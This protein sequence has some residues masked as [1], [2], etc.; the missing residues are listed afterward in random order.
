M[1][2]LESAAMIDAAQSTPTIVETAISAERPL[3][4]PENPPVKE[5]SSAFQEMAHE[6]GSLYSTLVKTC[7]SKRLSTTEVSQLIDT[8]PHISPRLKHIYINGWANLTQELEENEQMAQKIQEEERITSLDTFQ[9]KSVEKQ[10]EIKHLLRKNKPI[11]VKRLAGIPITVFSG[12]AYTTLT[13]ENILPKGRACLFHKTTK[14][15]MQIFIG[16]DRALEEFNLAENGSAQHEIHHLIYNNLRAG[17]RALVEIPQKN[18]EDQFAFA[19]FQDEMIAHIFSGRAY[20]L[21]S[22]TGLIYL[23]TYTQETGNRLQPGKK[24]QLEETT[25]KNAKFI[26]LCK[27]LCELKNME[28]FDLFLPIMISNSFDELAENVAS[29]VPLEENSVAANYQTIYTL[30]QQQQH[31]HNNFSSEVKRLIQLRGLPTDEASI[32]D[33]V[34]FA[35]DKVPPTQTGEQTAMSN[36]QKTIAG[37]HPFLERVFGYQKDQA[38][39]LN[40]YLARKMRRSYQPLLLPH[41]QPGQLQKVTQVA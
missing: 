40:E 2:G 21:I 38:T 10:E 7:L 16:A 26:Q 37:L 15:P 22:P 1:D 27:D 23:D 31:I 14:E 5:T 25:L 4:H 6:N 19:N 35:L 12:S 13:E 36:R 32:N 20:D 11:Y 28:G 41:K 3:F 33:F 17:F 18:P 24:L 29:F 8:L 39:I 9:S 30:W 34:D